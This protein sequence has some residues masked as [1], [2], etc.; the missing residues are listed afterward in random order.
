M[1][2]TL[3]IVLAVG[4][5]LALVVAV[6]MLVIPEPAQRA[7][8]ATERLDVA[9]LTFDNS[10]AWQGAGETIRSRIETR[11]VNAEGISVFSRT[12]LD[13]LLTEQLLGETGLIDQA[14]AAQIGSLT[15]VSK[16]VTGTV[17]GV[18]T[19]SESTTVCEK[20]QNGECIESVPATEYRARVI[21]QIQI[22]DARTGQI[23]QAFDAE[24]SESVTIK[25]GTTFAGYEMLI[26]EGAD[27]IA[28]DVGS[29]LTSTYTRELRYGL[30]ESV[31]TK[32][33]GYIGIGETSRFT[34]SGDE[35]FLVVHFT[36]IRED[37]SFTLSWLDPQ[38]GV[39]K[40]VEDVVGN[41]DW[42]VYTL[43]LSG[44]AG[45][46]YSVETELE[47]LGAFEKAFALNP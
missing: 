29:L 22:V 15:G 4:L 12:R 20:W 38:G 31:K 16:L 13:E 21:G 9:V 26:A 41:G 34:S 39:V 2:D 47:G 46:R 27:E 33:E 7:V 3:G 25:E 35:A 23:E 44:L 8:I 30:Y 17:Y 28:S 24:D 10:S 5:V 36:R 6:F 42:R 43:D 14:T 32:R 45:G 37:E 18:E 40:R 1:D 11:L 19:I